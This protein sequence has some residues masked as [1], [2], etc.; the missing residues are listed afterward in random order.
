MRGKISRGK[1]PRFAPVFRLFPHPLLLLE[2]NMRL[3][4]FPC[5]C[6][7]AAPP[8][9]LRRR[10][11]PQKRGAAAPLFLIIY[12]VYRY[13]PRKISPLGG[14]SA[15]LGRNDKVYIVF[16]DPFDCAAH[17]PFAAPLRVTYK[18]SPH[19]RA[20]PR[21]AVKNSLSLHQSRKKAKPRFCLFHPTAR[22]CMQER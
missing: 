21:G 17:F 10:P 8:P 15:L 6:L 9:P 12:I 20:P 11:C 22:S 16:R 13:A 19:P 7:C 2:R 4:V 5:A 14:L 18:E 1:Q 3:C